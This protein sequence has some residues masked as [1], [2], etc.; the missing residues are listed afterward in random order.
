MIQRFFL[1][2]FLYKHLNLTYLTLIPKSTDHQNP[3]DFRPISLCNTTYKIILKLI[4]NRLKL[5]LHKIISLF[6]STYVLGR[7]IT[8]NIMITQEIIYI[9]K[10]KKG[11][12]N[13]QGIKIDMSKAFDRLEWMNFIIHTLKKKA[14]IRMF[15]K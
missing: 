5:L 7:N 14:L 8:D 10:K 4:P 6:Q 3:G 15:A 12:S 2:K 11:K 9:M 13:L 1:T